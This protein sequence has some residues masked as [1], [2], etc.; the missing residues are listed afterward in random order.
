MDNGGA[1]LIRGFNR[2]R[3]TDRDEPRMLSADTDGGE[4][5]EAEIIHIFSPRFER[6]VIVC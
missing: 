3:W 1:I 2:L 4:E 6:Q 5:K